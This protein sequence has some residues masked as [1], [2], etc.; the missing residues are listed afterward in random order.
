MQGSRNGPGTGPTPRD[1]LPRWA[2]FLHGLAWGAIGG[3][4]SSTA[5]LDG[6]TVRLNAAIDLHKAATGP[7]VLAM[8]QA[9][10]VFTPAAWTYAALH[11][12]YGIA[13]VLK[14]MALGDTRWRRRVGPANVLAAWAFLTLYWVAPAILVLGT[15]G[16]LNLGAWEPSGPIGL[17]A[18]V[19]V[20]CV[21]LV[22]ML[23]ADAQKNALTRP[24]KG[25]RAGSSGDP[26]LIT[27]GFFARTR[28]PNYLGEMAIYSS[29]ALVVRHWLP[30]LILVAVW[31]L[32]F[33]PNMLAIE[34]RLSRYAGYEA[35][36][37]RTGFLLP[38]L[39]GPADS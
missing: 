16:Y 32:F 11:G 30:W 36:R 22:L 4:P 18:A 12:T 10:G 27:T 38:R 35:W 14:D 17:T 31:G 1:K 13:W 9:C 8:M 26:G 33:V 15:A 3:D 34:A 37:K 6:G 5:G 2:A 21:G 23:G 19:V 24:A 28:H 29:F 7:L 39:R 25:A 20:C